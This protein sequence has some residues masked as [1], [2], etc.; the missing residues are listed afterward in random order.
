MAKRIRNEELHLSIIING[1]KG[2]SELNS[3]K[4]ST[5][6]LKEQNKDLRL[7]K[8][9]LE[10]AGKTESEQ[11]KN[12]TAT[13]KLNSKTINEN[14]VKIKTLTKQLGL[15]GMSIRELRQEYNRLRMLRDQAVPKTQAWDNYN[16][17]MKTVK[18]RLDGVVGST[19][20]AKFSMGK[21]ADGFNRFAL[22]GATVIASLTGISMGIKKLVNSYFE[23]TDAFADV[24]KTTGLTDDGVKELYESLKKIDTRTANEDLLGLSRIAGKLGIEGKENI[25][26]FVRAS[27]Q[28]VVALGED[29]GGDVEET[30]RQV[31]KL[32]DIF[33]VSDVHGLEEGMLKVGSAIN[34]L[35]ASST[36]SE[37]Y[38]VEFTKRVGGVAQQSKTSIEDV[39]GLAATLDQLG[40]T[41]EVSA[42]T[43]NKVIVDMFKD[44][45]KYAKIAGMDVDSFS[46]LLQTN[47]NEAFIQF[48]SGLNGNNE[49]LAEMAGKLNDLGLDGARSTQVLATLANNT[50]LLREQQKL[51]NEEFKKGT[52]L[53]D[54]FNIKNNTAAARLDKAK[55]KV[56]ETAEVLGEKLAPVMAATA[57][58]FTKVL[59]ALIV[60]ID[61]FTKY[62]HI[63]VPIIAAIGAYIAV[64]QTQIL[65]TKLSVFWNTKL[66][67]S[68]KGL[69]KTIVLNPIGLV[70]AGI[71]GLILIYEQL[72]GAIDE[73]AEMQREVN[74]QMGEHI[75][76]TNKFK[77]AIQ[78]TT[79][80]LEGRKKVIDELK[81]AYPGLIGSEITYE[82]SQEQ[83]L[84]AIDRVNDAMRERIKI[85]VY[86]Q[87]QTELMTQLADL[88]MAK[89]EKGANIGGIDLN[90]FKKK[91]EA[92][93]NAKY[94]E[95]EKLI[96][97][98]NSNLDS[99]GVKSFLDIDQLKSFGSGSPSFK[100]PG[101]VEPSS[102]DFVSDK[103]QD[104]QAKSE[105]DLVD[106][107]L[108]L[109]KGLIDDK[110]KLL[111]FEMD[112]E[113]KKIEESTA[114]ESQKAEARSLVFIKYEKLREDEKK[115]I[116]DQEILNNKEKSDKAVEALQFGYEAEKLELD[117]QYLDGK[118][119]KEQH[120][121]ELEDL[122]LAHQLAILEIR[123][124]SGENVV[125]L[126]QQLLNKKIAVME[127]E[128]AAALVKEKAIVEA[129]KSEA[130]AGFQAGVAAVENAK[131]IEEAGKAVINA[132]R[133]QVKKHILAVIAKQVAEAVA[134]IPFPLN[135]VLGAVAGAAV[136]AL[137]NKVVP[138]F[139]E[140][141]YQVTGAGTGKTYNAK[142]GT[143]STGI[144]NS[145]TLIPG[146][147]LVGE[148]QPEI[149]IDGKTTNRILN[150]HPE[151]LDAIQFAR[152]IGSRPVRQ[153]AEGKYPQQKAP[154]KDA[155]LYA[156][157]QMNTNAI[158]TLAQILQNGIVAKTDY[159]QHK[160]V[161]NEYLKIQDEV[162][163]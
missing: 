32:V 50:E 106:Y 147:G 162:S 40:Q 12:L 58:L 96:E 39:L 69:W 63:I 66:G 81:E 38:L 100:M 3:L 48:L 72:T 7:E 161:E 105:K 70:I 91:A 35:G 79:N 16:T 6:Q 49:G 163:G 67:G 101:E 153:F 86:E 112:E 159:L 93:I 137:F 94:E 133:E 24:R 157:M 98:A 54:E 47:A 155:E 123:R 65:I 17:Q 28:L 68:F 156:I 8:R 22:L 131:T 82:S 84:K 99:L 83:L 76:K 59:K 71:V 121:I 15:E 42:T 51:S 5:R 151:I 149:V 89:F 13:I 117:N 124:Q 125:K 145:P 56:Q 97:D 1:D 143:G 37:G 9:K 114:I 135:L 113:L 160:E 20:K 144:Y 73:A 90:E 102:P 23:L 46:N 78:E 116:A 148:E 10:A 85:K 119:T 57:G 25:E 126:E 29:L 31:G 146:F 139:A 34:A 107:I 61:W 88:E 118:L 64:V 128:K 74:K 108:G 110:L 154:E 122:E 53:T 77:K 18:T 30:V 132:I 14:E 95:L 115:R 33:K 60:T 45:G 26:G 52:S 87:K 19:N 36:A 129:R 27:D 41:S 109:R 2:R 4:E 92:N 152:G 120:N 55:K 141:K 11:Y 75:V 142:I 130:D 21:L 158:S 104:K 136:T 140:G 127:R 138:Q 103:N 150:F 80:D 62:G 111:D 43:F 44:T 134:T